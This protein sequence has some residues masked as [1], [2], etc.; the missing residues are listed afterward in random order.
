MPFRNPFS[1]HTSSK[2]SVVS[3]QSERELERELKKL[4]E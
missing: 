2:K 3:K 1:R 4:E